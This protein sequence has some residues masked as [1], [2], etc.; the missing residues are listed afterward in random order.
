MAA[1]RRTPVTINKVELAA[2]LSEVKRATSPFDAPEVPGDPSLQPVKR[3]PPWRSPPRRRSRSLSRSASSSRSRSGS[4]RALR[5]SPSRRGRSCRSSP[6]CARRPSSRRTLRSPASP[7]PLRSP[8][9]PPRSRAAQGTAQAPVSP[10]L[11]ARDR[12]CSR[13]GAPELPAPEREL[14]YR[15]S[16]LRGDLSVRSYNDFKRRTLEFFNSRPQASYARDHNMTR[17]IRGKGIY[18]LQT[19]LHQM[20]SDFWGGC[21][22]RRLATAW[23]SPPAGPQFK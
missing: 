8:A 17:Q 18:F 5:R 3:Q 10:M 21:R 23:C 6:R 1:P 16:I 2:K 9:S 12:S 22:F 20:F 19:F 4:R 11:A 14:R 7:P 13:S 15:V